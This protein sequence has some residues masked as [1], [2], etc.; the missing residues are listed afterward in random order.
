ILPDNSRNSLNPTERVEINYTEK[1]NGNETQKSFTITKNNN[2]KWTINNKPNYVE[3]NQDNGKVVFS[4]NTI[5]PNS[6]ITITPKA[7]QGNT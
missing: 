3:F 6:Q 2:G 4:A 5:K 1:L 7:G